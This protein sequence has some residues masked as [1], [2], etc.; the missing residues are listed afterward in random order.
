M[1]S[2]SLLLNKVGIK[3]AYLRRTLEQCNL[4]PHATISHKSA[5]F[6]KMEKNANFPLW[7]QCK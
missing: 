5:V 6:N 3:S 4:Y 7:H 1:E 2:H